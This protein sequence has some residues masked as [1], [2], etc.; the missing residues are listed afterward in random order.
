MQVAFK[1]D[2]RRLLDPG[3]S[4][5]VRMGVH[6]TAVS[7]LGLALSAAA[8]V[9]V[10]RGGLR[11]GAACLILAALCD[12]LDGQLARRTG[13][14]SRFGAFLDSC[15]DRLGEGAV[16]LGLVL[17]LGPQGSMW[18]AVGVLAL[19][20]ST[21]VS[22]ARARAEGLGLDGQTGFLERPE[23]L[24]L[25]ILALLIGGQGLKLILLGLTALAAWTFLARVRHVG[26]QV[27]DGA[28]G[29]RSEHPSSPQARTERPATMTGAVKEMK[30]DG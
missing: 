19:L 27:G 1:E 23:R 12:V 2:A 21:M 7:L 18:V 17:Y 14:A 13:R 10:G 29:G 30:V 8:G 26:R 25:L 5:L 28:G 9:L 16:F 6:P 24:V 20:F 22:Y 4:L 3:V 11:A 15:L